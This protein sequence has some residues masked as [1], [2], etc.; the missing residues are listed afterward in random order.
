MISLL[1]ASA[2][3]AGLDVDIELLTVSVAH[4]SLPGV[5]SPTMTD[6]GGAT[7]TLL[8]QYQQDPLVLYEESY[9]QG[10]VVARRFSNALGVGFDLSKRFGIRLTLPT[11]YQWGTEI[12]NLSRS[13]LGMGDIT[14]GGRI[15][16]K[17]RESSAWGLTMDSYL[18]TGADNA[19]LGEEQPRILLGANTKIQ[20]QNL[21]FFLNGGVLLRQAVNT[22]LDFIMGNE[23]Q[24]KLGI[25]WN[26]WPEHFALGSTLISH[27]GT[28]NFLKGGAENSSEIMN[29]VQLQTQENLQTTFGV[30]KGLSTGYGTSEIRGF[31]NISYQRKPKPDAPPPPE[32]IIEE[33]VIPIVEEPEE[34][35]KEE[36]LAKVEADQIVIR[37]NI[38]FELGTDKILPESQPT[39]NYLAVLINQDVQLGHVVIEGHASEEGTDEYNYDLSNLRARSIY[40]SLLEAGV[41][42]DRLSHRGLGEAYPKVTDEELLAENRRVE[43]HIVRQDPPETKLELRDIRKR[44]WD[45]LQL[46][47]IIPKAKKPTANDTI[48]EEFDFNSIIAPEESSPPETE[49]NNPIDEP[50]ESPEESP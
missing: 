24:S 25:K 2:F 19:W 4:D 23:L 32:E 5:R 26:L 49:E 27:F 39:V 35:W 29:M 14:L 33:P 22:E 21:D 17:E 46:K 30:G 20:Q 1:I 45:G 31:V 44:P 40:R 15:L 3:G 13:G 47:S 11:T 10:A 12:P 38:Q 18:P 50:N 48:E 41:H 43:F 16:L 9:D 34:E 6:F 42:P 36:E 28:S 7:V 8:T 37:D